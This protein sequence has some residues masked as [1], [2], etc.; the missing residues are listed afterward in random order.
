VTEAWSL[1]PAP[2]KLN[3]FL[4]IVGRRADGYHELQTVFQL[5]EWGDL[6]HLRV[7]DDG[8]VLRQGDNAGIPAEADLAVRAARLLQVA[9]GCGAGCEIRIDKQIPLGGGFGGGSS[10]AATVLVGLNELWGTALKIRELSAIGA[11]LGADVPVFVEGE[12]AWAEGIGDRLTPLELPHRWFLVVDTGVCVPT[13]ELFQAPELT[14]DARSATIADFVSGKLRG[15]AFE[16]VLRRRAPAIAAALDR[17]AEVGDAQVT[18]SGGG[19]FVA[20][21]HRQAALHAQAALPRGWRSWVVE[22]A[23]SS[24]LLRRARRQAQPGAARSSEGFG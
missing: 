14:R 10:D 2:A 17:L 15:N 16:P 6:V 3:L 24:P 1:W 22:G 7:R 20:F 9:T 18:G 12:N 21:E 11:D 8:L 5:L 4:Q 19:V 13:A 23:R